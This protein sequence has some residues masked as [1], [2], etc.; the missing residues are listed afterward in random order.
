MSGFADYVSYKSPILDYRN[1]SRRTQFVSYASRILTRNWRISLVV[2]H[3]VMCSSMLEISQTLV[4]NKNLSRP[5][6][7]L[8]SVSRLEVRLNHKM[9]KRFFQGVR[10]LEISD[11]SEKIREKCA[12]LFILLVLLCNPPPLPV[13]AIIL[14]P[15]YTVVRVRF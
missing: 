12:T 8:V 7:F 3:P 14:L 11:I 6:I 1:R 10:T 2:Y 5:M 4:I 13:A 9:L 15:S